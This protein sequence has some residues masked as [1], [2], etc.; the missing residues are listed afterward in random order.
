M[1]VWVYT[2]QL[3]TPELVV[4]VLVQA[5]LIRVL[6]RMVVANTSMGTHIVR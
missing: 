4:V 6:R 5:S 2:S 1:V 3:S